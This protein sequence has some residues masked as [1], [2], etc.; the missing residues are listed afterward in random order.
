MVLPPVSRLASLIALCTAITRCSN[1]CAAWL[2]MPWSSLMTSMPASANVRASCA[3]CSIGEPC[4][5]NAV[6]V[7]GRVS[8]P[9]TVRMPSTP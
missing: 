1:G 8:T 5:F 7:S 6:Q 9:V 3:R 2:A 4:G